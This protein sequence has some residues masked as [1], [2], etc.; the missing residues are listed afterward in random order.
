MSTAARGWQST[1]SVSEWVYPSRQVSD[2]TGKDCCLVNSSVAIV[3]TGF[4]TVQNTM[5]ETGVWGGGMR[6]E[7]KEVE[8]TGPS[9]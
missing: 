2:A 8:S 9:R 7:D 6:L 5:E 1:A 4:E 3:T